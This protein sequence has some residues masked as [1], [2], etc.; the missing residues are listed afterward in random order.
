LNCSSCLDIYAYIYRSAFLQDKDVF[1]IAFN[2]LIRFPV[3]EGFVLI[4]A[5]YVF[6]LY[7]ETLQ[8]IN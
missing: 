3:W 2:A 1:A 8:Q 4:I 6:W 7:H 5:A